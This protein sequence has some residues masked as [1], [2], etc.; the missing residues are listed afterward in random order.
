MFEDHFGQYICLLQARHQ[1]FVDY[2]IRVGMQTGC[3]HDH[4]VR[5]FYQTAIDICELSGKH[6]PIDVVINDG[7]P[8]LVV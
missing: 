8:G 1:S 2:D 3:L 5:F 6:V 7:N 4:Q